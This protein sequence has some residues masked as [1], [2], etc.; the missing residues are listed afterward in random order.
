MFSL[1]L[2]ILVLGV[3]IAV[4][5]YGHF[6]AAR[7]FGVKV[8]KFSIG[9]GKPIFRYQKGDTEYSLS[10]IPL[11]GYI[12]M[13]GENP[14]EAEIGEDSYGEQ[15]WWKRATIAFAGPFAN[16]ILAVLILIF[17]FMIGKTYED[18]PAVIGKVEAK[19]A[20]TFQPKDQIIE[21]NGKQIQGFNQ[22]Q[23]LLSTVNN[24]EFTLKR[25]GKTLNVV[26]P[27]IAIDQ[28]GTSIQPYLSAKIGDVTPG[29]PAY[30]AGL[31]KGDVI[32]AVDGVAVK[33]WLDMRDKISSHPGN[34]MQLNFVRNGQ[35]YTRE[36]QLEDNIME[37]NK[38]MIGVSQFMP[39]KYKEHYSL[40]QSLRYGTI[41]SINVVV[42]NYV[43]F[44]KLIQKPKELKNNVGGPV[45]IYTMS[46]QSA[47]K[48]IDSILIFIAG[49]SLILMIM[50][51]LPIPIL[52]GGH[53]F[54]CFLEGIFRKPIP[55]RV[56]VVLQQMGFA[57][58]LFL[59]IYAFYADLS[60]ITTRTFSMQNNKP[61]KLTTESHK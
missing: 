37:N 38:K 51:L 60:R 19:Y 44:Y 8:E 2:T 32:T 13:K 48:G 42:L 35:Q 49:I 59:M 46:K 33:D 28:W 53:I 25:E 23:M 58:L 14:D 12:K 24:N 47:E 4:H 1:L 55:L 5:E 57:V 26:I 16:L 40:S 6:I 9:F 18:V 36:L 11:G 45:M 39:I 50:N 22:I 31:M 15:A 61:S 29:L 3:L 7:M 21:V 27:A 20:Q 41:F 54:F 43:A 56:Q 10:W 30:R 34:K 17:S 52:D